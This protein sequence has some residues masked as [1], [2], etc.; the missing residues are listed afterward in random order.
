MALASTGVADV[1]MRAMRSTSRTSNAIARAQ[2]IDHAVRHAVASDA[3]DPRR[4]VA[5]FAGLRRAK[6]HGP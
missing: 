3:R 5:S 1:S 6:R 2:R 4:S